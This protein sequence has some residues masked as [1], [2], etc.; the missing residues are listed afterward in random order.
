MER[1]S[2]SS[3]HGFRTPCASSSRA[4]G[5]KVR[6]L[7]LP[8]NFGFPTCFDKMLLESTVCHH[9]SMLG[10]HT[11]HCPPLTAQEPPTRTLTSS[12]RWL[13]FCQI[14]RLLHMRKNYQRDTRVSLQT[15][16]GLI[17]STLSG[18]RKLDNNHR[19]STNKLARMVSK[20]D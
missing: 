10:S 16:G 8:S 1:S 7:I 17:I 20:Q 19:P 5:K 13:R 6:A 9:P 14:V 15:G 18:S 4:S 11:G 2:D 3:V 12:P